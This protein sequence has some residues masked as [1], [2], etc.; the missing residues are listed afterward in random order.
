MQDELAT[1][2]LAVSTALVKRVYVERFLGDPSVDE[3]GER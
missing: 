1:P 2:L 3:K